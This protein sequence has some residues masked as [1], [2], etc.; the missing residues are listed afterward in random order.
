[1]SKSKSDYYMQI[2]DRVLKE[3]IANLHPEQSGAKAAKWYLNAFINQL[4]DILASLGLSQPEALYLVDLFNPGE[5]PE[6][7]ISTFAKEVAGEIFETPPTTIDGE[8]LLQKLKG[9]SPCQR[10]ALV[11]AINRFYEE[12]S[13]YRISGD[14]KIQLLH[15]VGLC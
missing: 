12:F 3:T 15:K 8:A 2:G 9:Y 7:S 4:P 14:E 10:I 1:M 13:G 11:D 6:S 5:I